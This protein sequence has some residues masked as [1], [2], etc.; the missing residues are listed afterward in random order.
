MI[1]SKYTIVVCILLVVLTV[2]AALFFS[3]SPWVK[4]KFISQSTVQY[5]DKIFNQGVVHS[6]DIEVEETEFYDML[7]NAMEKE[8]IKCNL[9]IDGEKFNNVAI[10]TKGNTSLT[11][12]QSMDSDRYSF[13]VEFDHY[14]SS[15]NYYG[16]DK[17][18][19]NNIIQDNTY[20]KDYLSYKMMNDMGALAP[21]ASFCN[22]T[23]NGQPWG[24]YLAAEG[25]EEGFLER[26]FGSVT[27]ELYKPDTMQMGGGNRNGE[28]G[29]APP[30]MG[31]MPQGGPPDMQMTETPPDMAQNHSMQNGQEVTENA[32]QDTAA[33]PAED[34]GADGE[35]PMPGGNG[36]RP[37]MP[38]GGGGF[39]GES[40]ATALIYTDDDYDSYST[41]FDS[42]VM[43]IDNSDK[44][45]LISSLKT[46]NQG[47]NPAEAVNTD[48]VIRYFVVHNFVNSYDSYT[49]NMKHNYYLYENNGILSMVAWDYNLAFSGFGGG[50][51]GGRGFGATQSETNVDTATEQINYPIDTP[52]SGASMED[53]PMLAW[54]FNDPQYLEQYHQVFDELITDYF[55]SGKIKDEINRVFNMIAPYVQ[56]DVSAFCTFEEF[57]EGVETLKQYCSLRAQ[58]VRKQL[59]GEIPSTQEGQSQDSSNFVDASFLNINAMGNMGHGGGRGGTE[60]GAQSFGGGQGG[61]GNQAAADVQTAGE[62]Q[63]ANG[64]PPAERQDTATSQA[65][66]ENQATA[67]SQTP[68][69][70]QNASGEQA[71]ASGQEGGQNFGDGQNFDRRQGTESG[72]N[73][74]RRMMPGS[75]NGG[76]AQNTAQNW[77]LYLVVLLVLAGG[78]AFAV[79]YRRK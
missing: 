61:E 50:F 30:D 64:Q 32:E 10:R 38:G 73:Q 69:D 4:E 11:N 63:S 36:E 65:P 48:E 77:I 56:E 72:G 58:S 7:E 16:L 21:L 42:A 37:E 51:G 26:N 34:A 25:I 62:S 28:K 54:I 20:M 17:L 2:F 70:G 18:A 74:Q 1:K 60:N 78:I 12:V 5:A 47:E 13:K 27:G 24:L 15:I 35:V 14:D 44:D 53:R 8:Y 41:I 43:D 66:G 68:G 22:I 55:E 23:L 76:A 39:G 9:T 49:G 52:L 29:G 46:L 31:E 71:A 6:I 79:L 19:L 75:E 45:R 59:N 67:D 57:E 33:T 40:D 3:Y